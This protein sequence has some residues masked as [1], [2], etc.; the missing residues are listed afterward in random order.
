METREG[1]MG[2]LMTKQDV[3]DFEK[4]IKRRLVIA[5][6]ALVLGV[7]IFAAGL[8][9]YLHDSTQEF[10]EASVGKYHRK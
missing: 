2:R 9:Y 10:R 5:A 8:M 3:E 6:L 4:T 7:G 1:M